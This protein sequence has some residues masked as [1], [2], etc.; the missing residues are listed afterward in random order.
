MIS[1]AELRSIAR[2]RIKDAEALLAAGRY[3][4]SVYLCGYSVESGLKAR[5]CRTL[6]WTEGFPSTNKEFENYKSFR[7]HNLDVLLHLSGAEKKIK[8]PNPMAEWSIV[9]AWDP[10]ARYRPIGTATADDATDMIKFGEGNL[11]STMI[12]IEKLQKLMK[13][14]EARKGPFTLFGVF[15]REES[16]G[17]W[18]L[19]LSAPWL[20]AGRL[21]A[22]GEFT[23]EMSKALGQDE[24]M[25]F[26][27]IVTLNHD[28]PL[29]H[30]ILNE[31]GSIKKPLEKQG[32]DLFGLPVEHAVILR[33]RMPKAA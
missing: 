15:M 13:Q 12:K 1:P 20:E 17:L 3:D 22:L 23:E 18:D 14:V 24:V 16:P 7:T 27:R 30:E 26:S 9:L 31:V 32:H 2:A 8:E 29:L 33:G 6:K 21:K 25:S 11:G 19:V 5:I 4:G 28:D 10:D